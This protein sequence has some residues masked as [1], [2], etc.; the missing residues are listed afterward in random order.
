VRPGTLPAGAT[1]VTA[2]E[3]AFGDKV[4]DAAVAELTKRLAN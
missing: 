3:V 4:I 2:A 1:R